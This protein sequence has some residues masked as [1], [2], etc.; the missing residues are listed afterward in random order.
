MAHAFNPSTREAEAGG[1][2]SSRSVW[3]TK[4]V[5]RQPGLHRETLSRKNKQTNKQTKNCN[6]NI[7][8]ARYLICD[9]CE[10]SLDAPKEVTGWE[11]LSSPLFKP[12]PCIKDPKIWYRGHWLSLL[13][14][15]C[16]HTGRISSVS[17]LQLP[18]LLTW[19]TEMGSQASSMPGPDWYISLRH[20]LAWCLPLHRHASPEKTLHTLQA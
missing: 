15:P 2:L 8:Y 14:F 9:P 5:P 12:K 16:G 3:S 19:P 18:S 20:L 13:L 4:W 6:I 11:L 17:F 10:K 7:C 1:F